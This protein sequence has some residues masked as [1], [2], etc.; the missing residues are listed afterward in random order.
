MSSIFAEK[1]KSLR[2]EYKIS[3][4]DLAKELGVGSG[5]ISD[6]ER[7]QRNPSE[8]LAFKLADRFNTEPSYWL[9]KDIEIE[10]MIKESPFKQLTDGLEQLIDEGIIKTVDDFNDDEIIEIIMDLVKVGF[11]KKKI[12]EI[13]K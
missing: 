13:K 3:Q 10:K 4:R 2:K 1:L 11:K 7:G 12:Q 9:D 5:V 6:V 8:R